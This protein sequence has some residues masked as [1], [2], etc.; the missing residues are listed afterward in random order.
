MAATTQIVWNY[1]QQFD[2]TINTAAQ[3]KV[4]QMESEGK[5]TGMKDLEWLSN[6]TWQVTRE[7][8]STEAAQE[9]ID[10]LLPYNPISA[11]IIN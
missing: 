1:Q 4:Q 11:N 6:N 3:A 2:Q 9:W 8:V 10:F 5:T 7:W